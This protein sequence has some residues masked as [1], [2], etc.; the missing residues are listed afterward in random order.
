MIDAHAALEVGPPAAPDLGGRLLTAVAATIDGLAVRAA[1]LLVDRALMPTPGEVQALR[2]SARFYVGAPFGDDPRRFFEFL[3][4]TCPVPDVTIVPRRPLAGNAERLAVT[5][6]SAY[7]PAN[8]AYAAEHDAFPENRVAHAELW[9]HRDKRPRATVIGLHGF[10]MGHPAVD[11]VVLMAPALFAAGLDVALLTLPLHGARA[12]RSTRFSG[13]LFANPNVPRINESIAQAVHDVAALCAWLRAGDGGPVG[14]IGLSLG[15]YVAALAAALMDD[16]AF[17]IP[18]VAPACFGD[19]AHRF[20]AASTLY[21]D[22][23]GAALSRE[24]FRAVYRVHSPLAHGPRLPGE[25]VLIVAARGDRV[26]PAEHAIWLWAHWGGPQ[27]AWFT[28]SH[29]VPFGRA[30][31][32]REILRFLARRGLLPRPRSAV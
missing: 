4:R 26:V 29:L 30:H 21:R 8:P 2:A 11:A 20:M 5:F 12:P 1:R 28:G 32:Q 14:I 25:R 15:G 31:V 22:S 10:G 9:R 27:L 17:A 16:L 3:D 13:Q 7:R 6:P 24:E 23:E 18:I 19:L